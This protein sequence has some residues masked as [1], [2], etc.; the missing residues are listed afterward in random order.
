MFGS[1]NNYTWEYWSGGEKEY[2][3]EYDNAG[4]PIKRILK[5]SGGK[6]NV[7]VFAYK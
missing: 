5:I 4:F 6:E 7:V 1:K 3:Y 2:K